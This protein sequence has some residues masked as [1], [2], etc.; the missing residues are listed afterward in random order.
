MKKFNF[1]SAGAFAAM[2]FAGLFW[3]CSDFSSSTSGVGVGGSSGAPSVAASPA[4]S[5]A[6]AGSPAAKSGSSDDSG[7]F[8]GIWKGKVS[9]SIHS[10]QCGPQPADCDPMFISLSQ[11]QNN[12][13]KGQMT[14]VN[15]SPV[16]GSVSGSTATITNVHACALAGKSRVVFSCVA[17]AVSTGTIHC[18][19]NGTTCSQC[20]VGS[21][22][23]T[24]APII[25][26]GTFVRR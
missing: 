6:A 13:L 25:G 4:G 7:Y 3:A 18:T 14:C 2:G 19:V 24:L 1:K 5:V 16:F 12:S 20:P 22:I 21:G 15:S 11:A 26:T 8:S 23:T 17:D 9:A 10:A